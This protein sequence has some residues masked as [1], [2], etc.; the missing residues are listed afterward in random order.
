MRRRLVG[1]AA[2]VLIAGLVLRWVSVPLLEKVSFSKVFRDRE[3]RLLRLTLSGDEKFR[4]FTPLDKLDPKLIE[5]VLLQEDRFFRYH[6]GVNPIA[7]A[8]V[9]VE[10]AQG[11]RM[12]GASTIT[13]QLVR[14]R[15][16]KTT[17]SVGAKF[18]Q[19]LG[20]IWLECAHSK[21]EILEAYLNLAP[22]GANLEGVGAASLVYF[23]KDP[24]SLKIGEALALALIPQSPS[25]RSLARDSSSLD[26]W[27]LRRGQLFEKWKKF[28]PEASERE[29]ELTLPL[30]SRRLRELPFRA[31]HLTERLSRELPH[32]RSLDLSLDLVLQGYVEKQ[33]RSYVERYRSLGV[34]NASALLA[35]YRTGQVIAYVGSA[36][37]MSSDI[38]GQV[39]GVI[40]RRSPGSALKPFV[41]ALAL[42]Q[43]VVHSETL[44]KDTPRNYGSF[45]PENF[46]RGFMGPLSTEEAL[47]RSR[48][49]PAVELASKLR[50][51]DLYKFLKAQ[52]I[53]LHQ[54]SS[55]YGLGLS[56]GGAEL[57][58]E[59]LV[60]LY[61]GMARGSP[62]QDLSFNKQLRAPAGAW[63]IGREAAWLTLQMLSRNPRDEQESF[64]KW[65]RARLEVAWK[66]GT[67]SGFR[68]AW[69]LG[70]FG[71]YV[72]GVWLG[73]FSGEANPAFIGRQLA[74]P[75]FFEIAEGLSKNSEFANPEWAH[76]MGKLNVKRVQ[77]CAVS[78]AEPE[79]FCPHRKWAWIIPGKSPIERCK[80]HRQILVNRKNGRRACGLTDDPAH[81][82]PEVFEFWPSD[83]RAS[84]KDFGI[85]KTE[86]PDFEANCSRE[87]ESLA[88][89]GAPEIVSPRK[90]M[91]Y[92]L[93]LSD[94]EEK[95]RIPLEAIADGDTKKLAWFVGSTYLGQANPGETLFWQ[96]KRGK[97]LLT[98]VDESGRAQSQIVEVQ[99]VP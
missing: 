36:D 23:S 34:N 42:E 14:L 83:L 3:G 79:P 91:L 89:H 99:Y 46:D 90:E 26:E 74:A 72:L 20:A 75:L 61:V 32:L 63:P 16:G 77:V 80:V 25:L 47:I 76:P 67:S 97:H 87:G 73:N 48:N 69:T 64:L 24:S 45:D 94:D 82:R 40:A 30:A 9:F 13:M 70:V 71:P 86:V 60:R 4:I 10:A 55:H 31:P 6:P 92:S 49:I 7:L 93:R 22:Y 84:F 51:P 37:F 18:F 78:G 96:A 44:V 1:L 8:K 12:R 39:D 88:A 95:R 2:F 66:T 38:S 68:D 81:Y 17:R 53:P 54:N 52:D 56:L 50:Q 43:G 59:E 57:S 15:A 35:D 28:H 29:V 62:I 85:H 41:Y 11:D 21:D 98:V 19:I 65:S 5:A 58:L 33:L 27:R